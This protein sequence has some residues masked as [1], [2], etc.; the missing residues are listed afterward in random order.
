GVRASTCDTSTSIESAICRRPCQ[1]PAF[2]AA[3]LIE[4]GVTSATRNTS[5][6]LS[7][8]AH[9]ISSSSGRISRARILS[10]VTLAEDQLE[11]PGEVVV[12]IVRDG[13]LT[14]TTSL[15]G[16]PHV[17]PQPIP[18]HILDPS[19]L[20][21]WTRLGRGVLAEHPAAGPGVVTTAH[22]RLGLP[23]RPAA[24]DGRSGQLCDFGGGVER[25]QCASVPLTQLAGLQQLLDVGR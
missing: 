17:S 12:G 9:P 5:R 13:E 24:L 16:E 3:S 4:P 22:Q 15:G 20:C 7:P 21:G 18:L 14:A 11:N 25:E 19:R 6:S 23:H 1:A 2:H 10:L 8:F